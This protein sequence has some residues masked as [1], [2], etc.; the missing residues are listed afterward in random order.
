MSFIAQHHFKKND[1]LKAQYYFEK[2]F[3][4]GVV[5]STKRDIYV[6]SI[7]NSPLT[8]TA[9]EKLVK[10]LDYKINDNARK[11]VELFLNNFKTEISN[12]YPQ[13][14][15]EHT[16][17]NHKVMRWNEL[18]ITYGFA[19]ETAAPQYFT[20]EIEN[21]FA[22]W[23]IESSHKLM[24]SREDNNPNILI[25][26]SQNNPAD[27][28]NK[29]YVVAYT[30]P[31]INSNVLTG[32]SI[33]FYTK[34]PLN[35][36]YSKNQVFNTALHEIA[37]ALGFMGHCDNKDNIMYLTKDSVSVTNDKRESLNI[38]DT[39]TI[40][41]LYDTKPDITNSNIK[42]SKYIPY[43]VL[44]TKEDISKAKMDE[45]RNYV[46]KAPSIPSGYIDLADGYVA[47]KNYPKAI[48]VL[49]RALRL[50][51]TEEMRGII[52]YNLAI[53]Y[54]MVDHLSMAENYLEKSILINDSNEKQSLKAEIYL[55][56]NKEELAIAKYNE[57]ISKEPRNIEYVISLTNIYVKDKK[58]GSARKVLK[59][60]IRKNP[61]E[62]N[63]KRL[64]CYGILMKFL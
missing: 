35:E 25:R 7:L 36:Y 22:E 49:D 47:D 62:K 8:T 1:M 10:F 46:R 28:K 38:A 5:D 24:F 43:L 34:D 44:G 20:K 45:A 23:E 27:L 6:N 26:Y 4:Y 37:H 41:L 55:K 59:E 39:E 50:A 40:T 2:A 63:N 9:Q 12:K 56:Q 11:K 61:S 14:Y 53:C 33:N 32:M 51:D 57:L 13:N 58:F 21:A 60:F 18:P 16:T 19:N 15:V 30:I 52:Y 29:K 42:E 3:D 48:K 17:F 64:Q 31:S 54:Y